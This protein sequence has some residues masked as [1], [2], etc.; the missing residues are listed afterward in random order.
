MGILARQ[1]TWNTVLT[2]AGLGLGF[3]NMAVLYPRHLPAAEFGLTRL[4]V[5]MAVVTAQLAHLGLEP[6]VI[7]YF[8]YFRDPAHRHAGLFRVVLMLGTLGALSAMV[9]LFALHDHFALWF[10]DRNGL[11]GTYGLVV[12]PLVLSE[13]FFLLLRGFSR[14]VH[15][16]TAAVFLRELLL[17][18]LQ[19]VLIGAHILWDLPFT[20]FLG[21]FVAAFAVAT[22]LLLID[23]WRAGEFGFK[24]VAVRVPRRM[25]RSMMRYGT[26]TLGVGVAGVAAGNVDQMMLAAMLPDGLVHVAYY[27]VALFLASVVTVPS[28]AM[29]MPVLPLLAEAWRRRDDDH[30]DQLHRRSTTVLLATGLFVAMCICLN[31]DTLYTMLN[32]EYASARPVLLLLCLTNVVNLAGGLGASIIS[33]SRSYAFD[34]TTGLLYFGLNV[35]LDFFFI[36]WVGMVGVAWSSL[37]TMAI[38]V[39]WRAVFLYR[40]YGWFPYDGPAMVKLAIACGA[41]SLTHWLQLPGPAVVE[42]GLRCLLAGVVYWTIVHRM[43]IAP[44][45]TDRFMERLVRFGGRR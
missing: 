15:R 22:L 33:T 44:E 31:I 20:W 11:Y 26:I 14:A 36:K 1:T 19:T 35:L 41:A 3:L 32:P 13:V 45:V 25:A 9:L 24:R 39:C 2:A 6:T 27:A 21:S 4:I 7:R 40:R 38:V 5:A 29:V 10:N 28:R 8:P 18:A 42:I 16:S 23:L 43:R 30:I 12:L 37:V 17:R 34:A